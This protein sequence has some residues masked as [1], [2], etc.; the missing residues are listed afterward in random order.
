MS[1][2][3]ARPFPPRRCLALAL[4]AVLAGP[5]AAGPAD[6]DARFG[7]GGVVFLDSGGT[8]D[9]ISALLPDGSGGAWAAGRMALAS[10]QAANGSDLALLHLR[11][12]GTLDPEFAGGGAA[13]ADTGTDGDYGYALARQPDGRLLVAGGLESGAY[14]DFGVARFDA[15]GNLDLSFGELDGA[16]RRGYARINMGPSAFVND[17]ARAVAV[18]SDGR[19]VL[20]GIGLAPEGNFNYQR[21]ALARV[22]ADGVLDPGFGNAGRVFAP[23]V[24]AQTAEYVTGFALQR[25]RTLPAD[26]S[27][28][29]VGY[30][31]ARNTAIVRRYD[32]QG[33]PDPA[34]DGDG[35]VTLAYGS[36]GGVATGLSRID[37]AAIQPDGRIVLVGRGGDRGFAFMRLLPGGAVDT[38]FGTNGRTLLKFSAAPNYDEP[39]GIAVQ[40]DG[41]IVA[42]G[43]ATAS[44]GGQDFAV[45]RLLPNGQPDPGFGNGGRVSYPLADGQDEGFAVAVLADG[46][47]LA[48]GT[49]QADGAT[50]LQ[51][52]AAFMRLVGDDGVFEDGFERD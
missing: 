13:Y 26:D 25:D 48:A 28:T 27:L 21:F 6:L 52:D 22:D 9:Q 40:A 20:A 15:H 41:S 50:G 37:A 38:S 33:V 12:D 36:T 51:R 39:A 5:A 42:T 17:E 4:C 44:G 19:I 8:D 3:K 31:F 35:T 1:R 23:A 11:A 47:L 49:A 46:S 7:F 2:A 29:V 24:Q 34:F 45:A 14:S 16:T 10:T 43:Y 30:A 18:Q 32:A